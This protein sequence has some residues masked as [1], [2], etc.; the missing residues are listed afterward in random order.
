MLRIVDKPML[1][2]LARHVLLF[3][4]RLT[5]HLNVFGSIETRCPKKTVMSDSKWCFGDHVS[6][7]SQRFKYQVNRGGNLKH[8][9]CKL[10]QHGLMDISEYA[11][12]K[13]LVDS[14]CRLHYHDDLFIL[15]FR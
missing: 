11:S 9:K 10:R 3:P 14:L 2:G 6:T 15:S 8:T 5:W 12:V 1:P 13:A 4:P 7:S